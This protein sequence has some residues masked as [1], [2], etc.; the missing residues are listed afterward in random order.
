M[1][2][3]ISIAMGA[4]MATATTVAATGCA[5]RPAR[6]SGATPTTP[7]SEWV[8]AAPADTAPTRLPGRAVVVIPEAVRPSA[9][10]GPS[11]SRDVAARPAP[12]RRID[13][14]LR[15]AE[16]HNALRL[17]ADTGGF[18]LVIEDSVGGTVNLE[19]E[20]VDPFDA[21]VMVAEAKGA[22]VCVR[23]STVIVSGASTGGRP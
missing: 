8:A 13:V 3:G 16:F 6:S 20:A 14:H 7:E 5:T 10:G 18:D 23:G 11:V 12:R 9:A 2:A 22:A 21:L 17:F 19:L 15:A 4:M 1:S